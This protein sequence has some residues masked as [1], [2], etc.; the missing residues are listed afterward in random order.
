MLFYLVSFSVDDDRAVHVWFAFVVVFGGFLALVSINQ[1]ST[2]YPTYFFY[3]FSMIHVY[4]C[5]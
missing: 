1:F 2:P 5:I 4:H 3:N